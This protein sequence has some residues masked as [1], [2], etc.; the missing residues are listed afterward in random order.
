LSSHFCTSISSVFSWHL[1]IFKQKKKKTQRKKSHRKEKK[2]EKGRE[3]TFKLSLYPLSFGSH[4]C[5]PTFALPFQ[6]L[7]PCIF[8]FSNKTKEKKHIK[9]KTIKKK[10]NAEKGGSLPSSSCFA[11]SFLAP[12]STLLFQTLFLNIFFF[13][14]KREGKKKNTKKKKP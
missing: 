1:F 6:M 8:F 4:T 9:I 3:L 10:K 12:A 5:P 14:N 7:S 11:F 2:C 13:S